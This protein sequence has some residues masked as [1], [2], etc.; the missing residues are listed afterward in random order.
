MKYLELRTI[1]GIVEISGIATGKPVAGE[2]RRSGPVMIKT[3]AGKA[4]PVNAKIRNVWTSALLPPRL[5]CWNDTGM[6]LM[7]GSWPLHWSSAFACVPASSLLPDS[8]AARIASAW[9]TTRA[10]GSSIARNPT[11]IRGKGMSK[12]TRGNQKSNDVKGDSALGVVKLRHTSITGPA[13]STAMMDQA[14]R[15]PNSAAMRMRRGSVFM[16][17]GE[18]RTMATSMS[19]LFTIHAE[20]PPPHY[21]TPE[22][23]MPEETAP[24]N[25]MGKSSSP[26][27]ICPHLASLSTADVD[28]YG[29]RL[30]RDNPLHERPEIVHGTPA[31]TNCRK[32]I[33]RRELWTSQPPCAQPDHVIAARL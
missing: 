18:R 15:K 32:W 20:R 5:R 27:P 31:H 3:H 6:L 2:K 30:N 29:C 33:T 10:D 12:A 22:A 16:R 7:S 9:P 24:V 28:R 23:S 26:G 1:N 11:V 8:A 13:R 21:E 19:A 14:K 17:W 25:C 4:I